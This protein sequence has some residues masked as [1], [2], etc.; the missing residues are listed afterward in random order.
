MERPQSRAVERPQ[1]RAAAGRTS[2]DLEITDPRPVI[3]S[4]ALWRRVAQIAIVGIFLIMFG[5]LLDLARNI[6]L[7]I[8]AAVVIGTMFGPLARIAAN[9]RIPGWLFAAV[10]V[11][12]LL[13]LLQVL[14]IMVL[15]PMIDW[16]GRAPEIAATVADK[17]KAFERGFA[18]SQQLQAA[19][20]KGGANAGLNIDIAGIAQ[21]LLG[22]LTPAIGELL[23]FFTTLFFFLL[24][25]NGMRKNI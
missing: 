19:L 24:D 25:R 12:F 9:R 11:G 1:S 14:T 3:A 6:L 8:V 21:P 7:P 5:G 22:F 23:I 16:L 20:S 15:V 10:M 17:L 13:A 2:S 18:A 4:G